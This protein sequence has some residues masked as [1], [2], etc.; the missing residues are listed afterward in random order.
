MY[1]YTKSGNYLYLFTMVREGSVTSVLMCIYVFTT[2]R[3][4]GS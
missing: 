4:R 2:L 1:M 3:G